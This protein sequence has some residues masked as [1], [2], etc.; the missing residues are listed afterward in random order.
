MFIKLDQW[1]ISM[2]INFVFRIVMVRKHLMFFSLRFH[3]FV[4][5]L[6]SCLF[7]VI[8]LVLIGKSWYTQIS[9]ILNEMIL[10]IYV[11]SHITPY[12]FQIHKI[13]GRNRCVD[14]TDALKKG[15][16]MRLQFYK[17]NRYISVT[18][19]LISTPLHHPRT[20]RSLPQLHTKNKK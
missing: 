16:I 13:S 15:K 10:H 5:R 6:E 1:F 2:F 9:D 12:R 14:E 4:P 20:R 19:H 17:Y 8:S 3:E 11:T 7:L 18:E